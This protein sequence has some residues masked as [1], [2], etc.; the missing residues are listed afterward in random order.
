MAKIFLLDDDEDV[1]ELVRVFLWEHDVHSALAL[2]G[3]NRLFCER[4]D[5]VLLDMNLPL[6]TG[7]E[8]ARI[9]KARGVDMARVYLFSARSETELREAVIELGVAGYIAKTLDPEL[10]TLR[11]ETAL[12]CRTT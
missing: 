8:V 10:L 6:V 7:K 5:L 1:H 12:S 2:A 11:F 9:L 3:A 4:F